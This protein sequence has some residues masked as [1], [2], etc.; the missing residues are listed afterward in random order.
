MLVPADSSATCGRRAR[1]DSTTHLYTSFLIRHRQ[2]ATSGNRITGEH[3]QTGETITVASLIAPNVGH[4]DVQADNSR[5][6][7]DALPDSGHRADL[8]TYLRNAGLVRGTV[9]AT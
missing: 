7:P 6:C 1:G 8:A 9:R 2:L 5:A 4:R 3:I